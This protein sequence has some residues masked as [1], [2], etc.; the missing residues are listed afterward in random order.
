M[1]FIEAKRHK[2]QYELVERGRCLGCSD[3]KSIADLYLNFLLHT[4]TRPFRVI[5]PKV[6]ATANYLDSLTFIS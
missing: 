1:G 4:R 2:L 5:V 3:F 6:H